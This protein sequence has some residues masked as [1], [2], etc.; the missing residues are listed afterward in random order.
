MSN[1]EEETPNVR[2]KLITTGNRTTTTGVLLIK[3]DTKATIASKAKVNFVY[4]YLQNLLSASDACSI[5]RQRFRAALITNIA[6]I[7]SG[8]SLAKTDSTLSRLGHCSLKPNPEMAMITPNNTRAVTST[9]TFSNTKETSAA[10]NNPNASIVS[11]SIALSD[12]FM[13]TRK[14]DR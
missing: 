8:A 12:Y 11:Q 14:V 5:T 6:A 2:D 3:A 9:L 4:P 1:F 13:A 10:N 7:V